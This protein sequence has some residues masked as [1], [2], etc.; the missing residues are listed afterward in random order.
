MI[1]IKREKRFLDAAKREK[2]PEKYWSNVRE[3]FRR[4]HLKPEDF[5]IR[6][7]FEVFVEDGREMVDSWRPT[8]TNKYSLMEAGTAVATTDFSNITGQIVYNTVIEAF[9]DPGF[10]HPLLVNDVQTDFDGEKI[11]GI[12]RIG[13]ESAIVPEMET[14]PYAGVAE[15]YVETPT[16]DKRGMIVPVTREA[17][18]FDRTGQILARAGEVAYWLGQNKE[19]RVLDEV[20]GITNTHKRRGQ[21]ETTYADTHTVGDFDNLSA[22]TAL[23]DWTD[24]EAAELLFDAIDDPNTGEPISIIPNTIIVPTALK[25]TLNRVLQATGI[26]FGSPGSTSDVTITQAA[27]PLNGSTYTAISGPMVK[28]RTSSDSTWFIG[29]PKRAF[30]YQQNWPITSV[31]APL[32]SHDEFERD[33]V[34]KYK[35]SER[36]AVATLEPRY[37]V[38]CTA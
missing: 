20:F 10:L 14:Y 9:D 31:Q 2:N 29:D 15:D 21:S 3:G 37:M 36:G 16:T 34:Q 30:S 26:E 7:C 33:I 4:K 6:Q 23:V 1:D 5:S 38:K 25:H 8:S 12:S 32:N 19:K 22:S 17:I 13:D 27:N 28:K 24:V 18:F 35:V 11:A